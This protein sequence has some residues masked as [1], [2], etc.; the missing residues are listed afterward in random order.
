MKMVSELAPLHDG[1]DCSSQ[2]VAGGIWNS[3][4]KWARRHHQML[5]CVDEALSHILLWTPPRHPSS[6]WRDVVWGVLELHRLI[7]D[8]IISQRDATNPIATIESS[9]RSST[10]EIQ[11]NQS[12]QWALSILQTLYPVLHQLVRGSNS[13]ATEIRQARVRKYLETIRF[14]L[15]TMLL[16]R[17]W[18]AVRHS[19][20]PPGLVVEG[21]RMVLSGNGATRSCWTTEE[22]ERRIENCNYVG[23]RTQK[24]WSL[25]PPIPNH[26]VERRRVQLGEIL[27]TL[28]PLLQAHS[29]HPRHQLV[30]PFLL[31]VG[32][33]YL[34]CRSS[35]P[36][37][38]QEW[39][40]R[41]MRLWLFLLR[42]PIW[43]RYTEPA[44][45]AV[46]RRAETNFLGRIVSNYVW[47]WLYYWKEYRIEE[48]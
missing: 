35:N 10:V 40:R 6:R 16:L 9:N 29:S 39:K 14:A 12:I 7:L 26:W 27:Y 19:T 8:H 11:H 5:L 47:E 30:V 45:T 32:A 41:R 31:E 33:L 36:A 46:S 1:D 23:R 2:V 25:Q 24:R 44:A 21:G 48:G 34:C 42:S 17:Y 22:E 18:R 20:A 3:Y 37:S 4:R 43:D 15:R 13:A 38:Q 28:R